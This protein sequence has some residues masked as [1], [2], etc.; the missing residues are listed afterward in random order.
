M[1]SLIV[2]HTDFDAVWP[3]AAEHWL[4]RW[5]AQGEARLLRVD[6]GDDC[7]LGQVA[8]EGGGVNRLAVLGLSVTNECLEGYPDLREAVLHGPTGTGPAPDV[9]A[10]LAARD[11]EVYRHHSE[12]SGASRWPSS[13]W[14]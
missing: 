10:R 3:F 14:P 6:G 4:D 5:R 12:D 1:S 2:V 8:P 13:G 11:V 7:R 9:E